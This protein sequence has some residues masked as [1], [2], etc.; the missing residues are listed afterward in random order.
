MVGNSIIIHAFDVFGMYVDFWDTIIHRNTQ[1][2][3]DI[4]N[5][6]VNA[7]DDAIVF[8]TDCYRSTVGI[9]H[10]G[11]YHGKPLGVDASTLAVKCLT[12][13]GCG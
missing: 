11:K 6:T 5:I 2:V 13:G 1:E 9:C 10:C 8:N 3:V 12:F 4:H 7:G